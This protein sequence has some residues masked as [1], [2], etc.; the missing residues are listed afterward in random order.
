MENPKTIWLINKD[1]APIEEY[2]THL[3]TFKQ[4]QYFQSK[5]FEVKILCSSIVHNTNI[6][7]LEGING[8]FNEE[9]HNGI[10]FVFIKSLKYGNNGVKRIL[11][12]ITFSFN[13]FRLK[14]KVKKPN[15]IIHTSRIPFDILIY[16]FAKRIKSKYILDI[17]DL[18]PL[19]FEHFGYLSSKN[20]ILKAFYWIEK[21]LYAKADFTVFSMEGC[22][23][24]IKEKKWDKGNGGII[25]LNK[26]HYINN[27][28]DLQEFEQNLAEY[29]IND[30]D[31]NNENTFKII[32]LGSI[33]LANNVS[34][35]IE[36]A[37]KLQQYNDIQFLIYG[38]GTERESLELRCKEEGINNVVFKDKWIEPKYVPYVLSKAAINIL[39]YGSGWAKYG[40][41]MNKMFMSFASGKPIVC[42]AGMNYS[43]ITKNNL[44][45]DKEFES[46]EEYSNA[47]LNIYNLDKNDYQLLCKRVKETS[48]EFDLFKLSERFS[49]LCKIE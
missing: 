11:A 22:Y 45:I 16:F 28:I 49:K 14:S 26:I 39:N 6:D 25:D 44:G 24:Y 31:L 36:V 1:S 33:R 5:G 32:Y 29:S 35:I 18:W 12:Y 34:Q 15:I 21:K 37:K 2:G 46:I 43:L 20:I 3:R 41:S 17:T 47:I 19:E 13:V 27:G 7:H 9:I 10:P 30:I 40:G 42:N 38:D 4:A 48:L 23:Y 8:F